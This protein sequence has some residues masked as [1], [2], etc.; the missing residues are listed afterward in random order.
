MFS[1]IKAKPLSHLTVQTDQRKLVHFFND[2]SS[3]EK[4]YTLLAERIFKE[5]D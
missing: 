4:A 5:Q 2:F 1:S 3:N